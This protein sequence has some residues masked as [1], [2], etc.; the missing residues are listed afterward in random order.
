MK[1]NIDEFQMDS[2]VVEKNIKEGLFHDKPN[3]STKSTGRFWSTFNRI[4]HAETHELIKEFVVCKICKKVSKYDPSKGISNLNK[5][6]DLCKGQKQTLRSFISR[7]NILQTEH[8]KELCFQAVAASILDIRTFNLTHG[9]GV[10]NLVHSVWNLGAQIG[11]VSAEE[12]RRALPCPTTISRNVNRLAE[13]SKE[14]MKLKLQTQMDSGFD[15]ALTTDIWQDKYKRISYFG[16]TVHFFDQNE[17]KLV[18]FILAMSGMETGRKKDHS[19]LEQ[20]MEE[21]L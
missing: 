21:K 18:D 14:I 3:T 4:F 19:Y 2:K 15:L 10:F 9:S 20:I 13:E 12:L 5:H 6:S 11:K 16:I 1:I 8:K 17:K 7:E